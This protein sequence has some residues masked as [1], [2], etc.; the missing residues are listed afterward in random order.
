MKSVEKGKLS[1]LNLTP[2]KRERQTDPEKLFRSLTLRGGVENIWEPQAAAL[3][4]WHAKRAESRTILEMNTGGG[5][6]LIAL[7][8]AQSLVN[9]TRGKVLYVCPTIQLIEQTRVQ[10]RQ[11]GLET[12]A[13]Y[14]GTWKDQDV[15]TES[16]GPCVTNY[17]ALC[18]GKSIFRREQPDALILDDAHVASPSIRSSFTLRFKAQTDLFTEIVSLFR[19]YFEKAGNA[20]QLASLQDGDPI[21][22][23]FVP[24]FEVNRRWQQLTKLLKDGEVDDEKSTLFV[25]E[26]LKDRL[27]RCCVFITASAVEITPADPPINALPQLSNCPR[28]I[29]MTATLPSP[30]QFARTFGQIAPNVIRPEGKSGE[31]QRL[32]VFA[33]GETDEEQREWT[34]RLIRSRKS[35]IIGASSTHA[36]QWTDEATLYVGDTGNAGLEQFKQAQP[37]KKLVMAAR[38][39]GI[40][41]PGDSC[42]VLVLDGLPLG[43]LMIDRFM[44]EVLHVEGIRASSTA[45]RVTQAIGRIFRS[46]TDHGVVIL[47]GT[48]LQ[49]WVSSPQNQAHLPDL[50]QRHLQFALELRKLVKTGQTTYEDLMNGILTGDP[51]WDR[52]YSEISEY[53]AE[54]RPAPPGWLITAA[55]NENAAFG[56]LWNGNLPGAAQHFAL[57]ADE[58]ESHDRGL[59]AWYR[60]WLGFAQERLSQPVPALQSYT[61][62]ANERGQ[63]GRPKVLSTTVIASDSAKTP[64]VQAKAIA[65]LAQN[66]ASAQKTLA[67]VKRD[68]VYGNDTKPAEAALHDMGQMLGFSASRPDN[69]KP[70]KTG[71]DVLW[72]FAPTNAGIALELKTDKKT[73]SQ[74]TKKEDIGQFHD[75]VQYLAK[76]HTG[77]TFLKVI[78]GR[79][80]TVSRES[81]PPDDLRIIELEEF[82]KLAHRVSELYVF[83]N[84]STDGD[85]LPVRAQRFI[86]FLGL[87][88]PKC[89]EGLAFSLA[90]D[91]QRDET[92]ADEVF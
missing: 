65:S 38:Y 62:A 88:W 55:G 76:K 39:D 8:I 40:D 25:W 83:I 91:L 37:P 34:K 29:Y 70:K 20:Q 64:G 89:V 67:K 80:L 74:Y 47:C 54:E 12:A 41:L 78:V 27:D 4:Q 33:E 85:T 32:F 14:G 15:F 24:S 66:L 49:K 69:T 13:Y 71:P 36:E 77:E 45:I 50:L 52:L 18:N 44:D 19:P 1:G 60:H 31:A 6:T 73:G 81:N 7:L 42:R 68:L 92:T 56:L 53:D 86:E 26:H 11:C 63:L 43:S 2:R 21:P 46:N 59:G 17:A 51:E 23:L 9:E 16:R 22:L 57:L 90:T 3:R 30:V 58:V 75:H 72:R 10:A 48:D 87:E 28:V 61:T 82:Q 84:A 5:K 79:L 35:C